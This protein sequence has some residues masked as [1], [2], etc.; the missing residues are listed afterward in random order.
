MTRMEED[1]LPLLVFHYHLNGQRDLDR[2][3]QRW[4]DQE[5]EV[6]MDLNLNPSLLF[7]I[8]TVLLLIKISKNGTTKNKTFGAD[9]SGNRQILENVRIQ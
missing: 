1:C 9:V 6:L 7:Q 3:K 8:F 5:E 2:T 4:H